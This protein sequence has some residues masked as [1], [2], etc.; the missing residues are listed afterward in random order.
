MRARSAAWPLMISHS[1]PIVTVIEAWYNGAQTLASV[2]IT[3]GKIEYDDT[4][5][6]KRRLK[7]TVPAAVPGLRLDPAGRPTSPLAN[8]G[9]RLH[10]RTGIEH[11]NRARELMDHGWFLITDWRHNEE[12]R[13]IGVDATDLARLIVDDRLTA[14]STPPAGATFVSEFT[15]LVGG[16]LPVVI[17]PGFPDR[18]LPATT[19]W[20]RERDTALADL[21]RSWPARW[22]VGDDGAAHVAAPY[23]PVTAATP[24]ALVLTDGVDGTVV[25]RGREG[26]RGAMYNMVVVDGKAPDGGGP[27][28]HAVAEITDPA[29]PI[30]V[31]GPYGRLPRFHSSD[32]ITTQAQ[33]DEAAAAQLVGYASV[34]R[35]ERVEAVPDPAV[36]LG[37]VARVYTRDGDAHT[38]RVTSLVLP[39][40]PDD[41]PMVAAV[42]MLPA[43]VM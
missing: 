42:S 22:Y 17:P 34:G 7:L 29:S 27:P 11:P 6:E 38:G 32:L 41:A 30:R 43:G 8:Y 19:V 15:R 16:I 20:D 40:T 21:C 31:A 23:G 1:H 2:P 13:T 35:S 25:G 37:D 18:L 14:P 5:V 4:A 26:Q 39:L 9:Q 36:E 33:A 12:D 28:P 3:N 24:P 10:V